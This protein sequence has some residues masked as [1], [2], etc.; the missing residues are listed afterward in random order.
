ME[1]YS[2][3]TLV[4]AIPFEKIA[5]GI[6]SGLVCLIILLIFGLELL[7]L[8]LLQTPLPAIGYAFPLSMA[9]CL[10][11]VIWNPHGWEMLKRYYIDT[12]GAWVEAHLPQLMEFIA[13]EMNKGL[14][15]MS[16]EELYEARLG[17]VEARIELAKNLKLKFREEM[18]ERLSSM[19]DDEL[20]A[21]QARLDS[22]TSDDD[23][24]YEVMKS[25]NVDIQAENEYNARQ[26]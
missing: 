26:S 7:A 6:L 12:Y 22:E 17:F 11:M 1:N 20:F 23:S 15:K 8:F 9:I 2:T 3:R 5:R 16:D 18:Q 25:K 21:L 4:D 24:L 13:N 14:A 10:L 19:S